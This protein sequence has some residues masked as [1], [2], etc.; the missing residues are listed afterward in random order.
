MSRS[1]STGGFLPA[2]PRVLG[3]VGLGLIGTSIALAARRRWPHLSIVGVDHP[4]VLLHPTLISTL[5]VASSDLTALGEADTVVL[6]APVDAIVAMLPTLASAVPR[7]QLIIDTGS[8]KRGIAAAARDAHLQSFVGGHPMAG[9]AGAGPGLARAD[10][11]DNRLW[12]LVDDRDEAPLAY[13]QAFIEGLGARV[14]RTDA[15]THDRVMAAVSHLP[16]LVASLLM[17]VVGDAVTPDGLAWAG[18]GLRDTT[19][20][21]ASP[22]GMWTSVLASNADLLEPLITELATRLQAVAPQLTDAHEIERVFGDATSARDILDRH[23][24]RDSRFS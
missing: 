16:Q 13:A 6:A 5:D 12:L 4:P 8:T 7:A 18:G 14:Q 20:L 2:S 10:L 23:L 22:A 1:S 3:V 11:F 21:A 15:E 9:A 19:R 17:S 24:A